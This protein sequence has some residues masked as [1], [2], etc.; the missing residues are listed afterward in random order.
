MNIGD[1][2]VFKM[3]ADLQK[4]GNGKGKG[5]KSDDVVMGLLGKMSEAYMQ[6]K[7]DNKELVAKLEA[8][9]KDKSEMAAEIEKLKSSAAIK[10]ST[11]KVPELLLPAK[12]KKFENTKLIIK[13]DQEDDDDD[14][15]MSEEVL[16]MEEIEK[17]EKSS[18]KQDRNRS[19]R[20]KMIEEELSRPR[21]YKKQKS[22]SRSRSDSRSNSRSRSRSKSRSHRRS[23]SKS[24]DD[25]DRQRERDRERRRQELED[26]E[27][28]RERNKKGSRDRDRRSND[29][30]LDEWRPKTAE[31]PLKINPTLASFKEK[32]KHKQDIEMALKQK[33]DDAKY[34]KK[35]SAWTSMSMI[36]DNNKK[37]EMMPEPTKLEARPSVNI[38]WG[39]GSKLKGKTPEARE[40][41][42][43]KSIQSFVG[44]MPKKKSMERDS[45]SPN[46]SSSKFGAQVNV[47]PPE[48]CTPSV[49]P[50]APAPTYLPIRRA[51]PKN[52]T[53]KNVDIKD[54]LAAAKAHMMARGELM[55]EPNP[56]KLDMEI[57]L[58]PLP[59]AQDRDPDAMKDTRPVQPPTPPPVAEKT[60]LDFMLEMHNAPPG[61]SGGSGSHVVEVTQPPPPP[62]TQSKVDMTMYA[63]YAAHW[64][65]GFD[66]R[67]V[68]AAAANAAIPVPKP[69]IPP[70]SHRH[71][72][73]INPEETLAA[74]AEAVPMIEKA[75][76]VI[77]KDMDMDAEELAMLGIDPSDFDG[78]GI[79][80]NS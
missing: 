53:P 68:A 27:R 78:F 64:G 8:L 23:R 45:V 5:K 3:V 1:D 39:S 15:I 28:E 43:K 16:K 59:A 13:D 4:S 25:R 36:N 71:E 18:Q 50:A 51:L 33:D 76:E 62:V 22:R 55:P 54:M 73:A 74:V 58:P 67:A 32:M 14:P 42:T 30:N 46:R 26:R 17:F 70:P 41:G 75:K 40:I 69:Q 44:K 7:A 9:E 65:P 20:A 38:Q 19:V 2:S 37:K 66:P 52:P 49:A 61:F 21:G 35:Q 72:P 10:K 79:Q 60:E 77:E 34:A 80:K 24:Y 56:Q 12:A 29:I 31:N 11:E 57:P 6:A 47:P 63:T 48:V